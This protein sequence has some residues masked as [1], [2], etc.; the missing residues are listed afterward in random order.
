MPASAGRSVAVVVNV[1]ASLRNKARVL[2][3]CAGYCPACAPNESECPLVQNFFP[4]G[5]EDRA[6]AALARSC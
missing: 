2:L 6:L 1:S 4:D 3:V 5:T